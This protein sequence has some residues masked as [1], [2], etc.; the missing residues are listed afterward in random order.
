[1]DRNVATPD[2][3]VLAGRLLFAVQAEL[4]SRLASFGFDDL[5]PRHGAVLAYIQE[6]GIRATE[7]ARRS[8]QHKQ[9]IGTLI[10]EL[11]DL[12]YVER[13]SDPA[14]RRAKLVYPTQRGRAQMAAADTIMAQMQ[15]RHAA[16]LG[17]DVYAEFKRVFLDVVENQRH[18]DIS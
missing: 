11:T 2:L 6:S 14:D 10:D 9:V 15:D 7:L 12:G 8:G 1:M 5:K 4:F 3:G 17:A 13:R 18:P 16:R